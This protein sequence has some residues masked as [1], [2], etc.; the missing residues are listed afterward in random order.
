MIQNLLILWRLPQFSPP[1]NAVFSLYRSPL[2]TLTRGDLA[3]TAVKRG[4]GAALTILFNHPETR[5][6]MLAALKI[7]FNHRETKDIY[8]YHLQLT[9]GLSERMGQDRTEKK[10][11]NRIE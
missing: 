1:W 5:I 3:L 8:C 6:T 4:Y 11:V 10:T 2:T 7:P 9:D